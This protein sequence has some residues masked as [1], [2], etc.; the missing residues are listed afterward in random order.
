[1]EI[2]NKYLLS[3]EKAVA[4]LKKLKNYETHKITQIYI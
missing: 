4:F 1:M 2:E 3:Y